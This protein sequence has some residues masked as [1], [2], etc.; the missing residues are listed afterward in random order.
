MVC[1]PQRAFLLLYLQKAEL[2]SEVADKSLRTVTKSFPFPSVIRVVKYIAIPYRGVVLTRHNVFKRDEFSC[3]YCGTNKDL[4]LDH[5]IPRSKGGKSN[6][7]NLV[8]AC[9]D[10]NS[11]KGDY[12]LTEVNMTLAKK[13]VKPSYIM[14][15]KSTNGTVRDDWR[16][17]LEP[18]AYA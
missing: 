5:L 14:F 10:C 1:S 4:T 9:K 2:L 13:P 17:Y 12:E 15:M 18:N 3:Q 6:W 11:R 16:K 8:T 7:T